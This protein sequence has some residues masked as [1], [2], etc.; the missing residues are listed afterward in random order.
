MTDESRPDSDSVDQ[1]LE[2]LHD[3][4]DRD[5]TVEP[6][7]TSADFE[8][9]LAATRLRAGSA[10]AAAVD[11]IV[12]VSAAS[13][14]PVERRARLL[15]SLDQ[16]LADRRR[17]NGPIQSVLRRHRYAA[18]ESLATIAERLS[19]VVSAGPGAA[20][21]TS[22]DQLEAV[23]SGTIPVVDD[24]AIVILASWAALIGLPRASARASFLRSMESAELDA[25]MY[26]AAGFESKVAADP[27][28]ITLMEQF[29]DLYDMATTTIER[30]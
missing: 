19:N 28:S 21:D 27:E 9:A 11:K 1:I 6:S 24:S 26:A 2:D 18:S 17:D 22:V 15:D 3:T 14:L 30:K 29:L 16:A 7:V 13:S 8:A 20:A 12:A 25:P 5:D 10:A 23:E 4:D